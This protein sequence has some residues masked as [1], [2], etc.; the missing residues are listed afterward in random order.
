MSS[1]CRTLGT[2]R[3][4][5]DTCITRIS[6]KDVC[7]TLV[8]KN[9][10][11]FQTCQT[12]IKHLLSI[13]NTSRQFREKIINLR[14]KYTSNSFCEHR[15]VT[16]SNVLSYLCLLSLYVCFLI[17]L[18]LMK[19]CSKKC[20]QLFITTKHDYQITTQLKSLSRQ[21]TIFVTLPRELL[22]QNLTRE[23]NDIVGIQEQ[24]LLL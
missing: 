6:I 5:F 2:L 3:H 10:Y 23:R 13:I 21:F 9:E 19:I 12:R 22:T 7:P 18:G 4:L 16:M 20:L 24:D 1:T 17:S 15:N 11:G 14:A 8:V